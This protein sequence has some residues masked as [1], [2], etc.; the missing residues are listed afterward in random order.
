M[1]LLRYILLILLVCNIPGIVLVGY[2]DTL[3]SL[4]SYLMLGLLL[5]F[6]FLNKKHALPWPFVIFA[7]S[8]FL[9]SGLVYIAEEEFFYREFLK[10]LI[11][12]IC[13]AEL[14][15]AT[16]VME[17]YYLVLIG[18]LSIV[19]NAVFFPMDYGRYSGLF[20]DPNAA[21]FVCLFGVA[22]SSY[23]KKDLWKYGS[24]LLFTFCGVFTFSRTFFLLWILMILI[25]VFQNRRNLILFAGGFIS[26][27][28]FLSV[29]SDFKLN[30]ERLNVLGS[31]FEDGRIDQSVS[32]DSR[33][34]TWAKYYDKIYE[35][36]LVGNGYESF[37]SD[38]IYAV[39]V[40][41]NY[42]RVIGD[43]G[44]LPFLI[45]VW[46]YV[47]IFIKS[48]RTF[49]TKPYEFLL[50]FSLLFL[51]L[52]NHNFDTIHHVTFVTIWLYFRVYKNHETSEESTELNP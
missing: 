41:N 6:Y 8:Y 4:M 33:S 40:H 38:N 47:Y 5:V 11:I 34:D 7:V 29:S 39:G 45:F 13:G 25:S 20:L 1:K 22:L 52:T 9:I 46:I 14:A 24:I 44:I 43:A 42:L 10:Y 27:V 37:K 18:A 49:K 30:T 36:P 17:L 26:V 15:R 16:K 19:I 23:I 31:L 21:G 35:S 48:L 51:G 2:G 12:I 3:G 28:L 32:S 50:A